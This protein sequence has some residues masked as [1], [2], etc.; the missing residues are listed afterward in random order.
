MHNIFLNM[1]SLR[2]VNYL[3]CSDTQ[4]NKYYGSIN[5]FF[6]DEWCGSGYGSE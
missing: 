5:S 2:K 4:K 6:I 1:G 3:T